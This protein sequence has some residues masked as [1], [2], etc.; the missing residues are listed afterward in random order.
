MFQ[1]I[2]LSALFLKHASRKV[3]CFAWWLGFDKNLREEVTELRAHLD[4]SLL[5]SGYLG[6]SGGRISHRQVS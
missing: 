5:A 1:E 3:L 2:E 4:N 6:L